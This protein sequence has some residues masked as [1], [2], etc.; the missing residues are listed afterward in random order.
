MILKFLRTTPS[1][2]PEFPFQPGQRIAVTK[3]TAEMR[4]WIKDGAAEL[5]RDD[6]TPDTTDEPAAPERATTIKGAR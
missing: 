5:I 1:A 3:L 6:G 4:A 2:S